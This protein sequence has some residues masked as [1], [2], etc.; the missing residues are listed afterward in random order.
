MSLQNYSWTKHADER[1]MQRFLIGKSGRQTFI[2][3]FMMNGGHF[4]LKEHDGSEIWESGDIVLVVNPETQTII[5]VYH[6]NQKPEDKT[7]GSNLT[8]EFLTD[9]AEQARII[10]K[11]IIKDSLPDIDELINNVLES[12]PPL[13]NTHD[14]IV[15][16]G[17]DSL[18]T[19]VTKLRSYL[20]K[21]KAYRMSADKVRERDI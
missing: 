10:K 17:F 8:D 21:I 2:S 1:L 18:Y 4:S 11:R 9:L 20:G 13:R 7:E 3:N 16:N 5:T 14:E 6:K 15:D 19:N 12:V